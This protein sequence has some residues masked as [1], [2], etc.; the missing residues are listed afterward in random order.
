MY[1]YII[2]IRTTEY[3][4]IIINILIHIIYKYNTTNIK[5]S[6]DIL[7][8]EILNKLVSMLFRFTKLY[9]GGFNNFS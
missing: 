4:I 8:L 5:S 9:Y 7:L 3:I 2:Y 1:I 6:S